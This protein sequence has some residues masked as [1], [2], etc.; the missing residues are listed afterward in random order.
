MMRWGAG[1]DAISCPVCGGLF[2]TGSMKHHLRTCARRFLNGLVNCQSCG[3]PCAKEDL[4]E[5]QKRCFKMVKRDNAGEVPEEKKRE[6][7]QRVK[8]I[9]GAFS[10]LE[11][12]ELG[13]PDKQG[14][15]ACGV[16]GEKFRLQS[17]LAHEAGCREQLRL[18][19]E[20][21]GTLL[22]GTSSGQEKDAEESEEALTRAH[23]HAL[24]KHLDALRS[25]ICGSKTLSDPIMIEKAWSLCIERLRAVVTNATVPRGVEKKYRRLK[26]KNEAFRDAVG[27][28]SN[29]V[30]CMKTMGFLETQTEKAPA[31]GAAA[32]ALEGGAGGLGIV[33]TKNSKQA[34]P[35]LASSGGVE[36]VLLLPE[37]FTLE[38]SQTWLRLLEDIPRQILEPGLVLE[39]CKYCGRKFRFDRIAK[40]ETRCM[41]G[42]PKRAK[43]D[44][45][46]HYLRGTPAEN[47]IPQIKAAG[48]ITKLPKLAQTANREAGRANGNQCP[49]CLRTFAGD[50]YVKHVKRCKATGPDAIM[51]KR[52][53]LDNMT[54]T[55]G[56]ASSASF[57]STSTKGRGIEG[58][59]APRNYN[60]S[61][62]SSSSSNGPR[63]SR[64]ADDDYDMINIQE[65]Q[66]DPDKNMICQ[67][68]IPAS[69][70]KTR[71][72]DDNEDNGLEEMRLAANKSNT[73]GRS[74]KTP[75]KASMSSFNLTNPTPSSSSSSRRPPSAGRSG[76]G[77]NAS[78]ISSHI[79]KGG[80]TGAGADLGI[81]H[82]HQSTSQHVVNLTLDSAPGLKSSMSMSRPT[83]G[84]RPS[85]AA[86]QALLQQQQQHSSHALAQD[87]N[88]TGDRN[89]P[90]STRHTTSSGGACHDQEQDVGKLHDVGPCESSVLMRPVPLQELKVQNGLC[91]S[92][93]P[94]SSTVAPLS[95]DRSSSA[96]LDQHHEIFIDADDLEHEIETEQ[97]CVAESLEQEVDI[98]ALMGMM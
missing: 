90:S 19:N 67:E 36:E 41:A 61:S 4:A 88:A 21:V 55:N 54:K 3:R 32:A 11:R 57:S 27:Q 2:S 17:I 77:A 91:G 26:R 92:P 22:A 38:G 14:R 71:T 31:A 44:L 23:A 82:P 48:K 72:L 20:A 86:Y 98:N 97:F 52:S 59:P 74:T 87:S 81:L 16:C 70:S 53:T 56:G 47:Y 60:S 96:M 63:R 28:W 75:R 62:S 24:G 35:G 46:A 51:L 37:P 43:L 13:L 25:E 39:G 45:V 65:E 1:R 6:F 5:H 83:S 58:A 8:D 9:K 42:K 33:T 10:A 30:A 93:T 29:A 94:S 18:Q 49:R 73:Y 78:A 34:T 89:R 85:S 64:V 12:G 40:H 95:E 84:G 80:G 7:L 50:S 66:G 68:I 15:F 76:R 69:R 79:I